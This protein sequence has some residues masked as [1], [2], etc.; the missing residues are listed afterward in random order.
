MP[1]VLPNVSGTT[2]PSSEKRPVGKRRPDA[3]HTVL[4]DVTSGLNAQRPVNRNEVAGGFGAEPENAA[5]GFFN[6]PGSCK[7]KSRRSGQPPL[8]NTVKSNGRGDG[9]V[10][11]AAR[12]IPVSV[13]GIYFGRTEGV[14]VK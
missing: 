13:S 7:F 11:K 2:A 12:D 14:S 1:A 6:L 4:S 5:L 9:I 10:G 3:L 8:R